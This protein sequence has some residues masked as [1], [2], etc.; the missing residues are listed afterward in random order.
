M[1]AADALLIRVQDVVVHC[2]DLAPAD[3]RPTRLG[4]DLVEAA[5]LVVRGRQASGGLPPEQFATAQQPR[6]G[7]ALDWLLAAVGRDADWTP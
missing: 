2:W 1:P 5:G 3:T 4:D 6:G 7:G